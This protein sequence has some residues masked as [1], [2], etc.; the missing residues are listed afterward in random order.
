MP[1]GRLRAL[2]PRKCQS[3]F[4]IS[5]REAKTSSSRHLYKGSQNSGVLL[6]NQPHSGNMDERKHGAVMT[7][8]AN[9]HCADWQPTQQPACAA[10]TPFLPVT[11]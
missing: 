2:N 8:D 1:R 9:R 4:R 5:G 11:K 10:A 7:D 3:I 6:P